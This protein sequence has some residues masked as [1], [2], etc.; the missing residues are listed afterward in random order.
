MHEQSW[1]FHL[2][3]FLQM[4]FLIHHRFEENSKFSLISFAYELESIEISGDNSFTQ[5]SYCF[6]SCHTCESIVE[7]SDK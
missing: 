2:K 3:N 5:I 7:I 1:N 4:C 6:M